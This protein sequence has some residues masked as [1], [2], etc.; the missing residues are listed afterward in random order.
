MSRGKWARCVV[1][2]ETELEHFFRDYLGGSNRSLLLLAGGGFDPRSTALAEK[3]ATLRGTVIT[4]VWLRERRPISLANLRTQAEGNIRRMLQLVPQSTVV[5][6]NVFA[7]DGAAIGG[8]E[9]VRF[10]QTL[11]FSGVTDVMLD[12]SALST[13]VLFSAAKFLY[14]HVKRS[15][16]T[17]LHLFVKKDE[18]EDIRIRGTPSDTPAFLHGFKGAFTLDASATAAKLWLP[19]LI[20]GRR[21]MLQN[22][23]AFLNVD[24][25]CPIL[26]FPSA[27][28]RLGDKL[29]VEYR[30]ALA[31]WGV[32]FRNFVYAAEN[33]PLD[34]YRTIVRL[35]TSRQQVF[36]ESGGSIIVLSPTGSKV[37][38]IGSLLAAL[39]L[40]LPVALFESLAYELE[41]ADAP[42]ESS[43]EATFLMHIWL[44]GEAY[45]TRPVR[46]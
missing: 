46:G 37:H 36:H 42:V 39:D 6:L 26:P 14:E 5:D 8:R 40:D 33:D 24:D 38:A 4:A 16:E 2:R 23:H 43:P 28:P 13:G 41:V 15:Q 7:E 17:N 20:P 3:L 30:D 35:H 45:R 32:D 29:V 11:N 18:T 44:E 27:D 1:Q 12:A 34:L 22:L 10:L 21:M 19:Q 31:A 9:I 25:V